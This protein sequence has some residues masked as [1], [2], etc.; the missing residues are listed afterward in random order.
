[1]GSWIRAGVAEEM[2]GFLS[3]RGAVNGCKAAILPRLS[4]L[5]E[6]KWYQKKD[7]RWRTGAGGDTLTRDF[8]LCN[9]LE[10]VG[11]RFMFAGWSRGDASPHQSR[12]L[13]FT[14]QKCVR[15]KR[16]NLVV[17]RHRWRALICSQFPCL[18][19]SSSDGLRECR[20]V[21]TQKSALGPEIAD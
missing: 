21:I 1:M 3:L 11:P 5:G 20:G 14:C 18:G 13:S 7:D 19:F 9:S 8:I 4:L 16:V 6:G 17:W 15:P 12:K 10:S 2:G